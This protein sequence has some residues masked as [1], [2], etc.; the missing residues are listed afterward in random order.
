LNELNDFYL[1]LL[2]VDAATG[3]P[4]CERVSVEEVLRDVL[5][6]AGENAAGRVRINIVDSLPRVPINRNAPSL[7]S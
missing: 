7:C 1:E 3:T 5:E 4:R 6:Q 2:K